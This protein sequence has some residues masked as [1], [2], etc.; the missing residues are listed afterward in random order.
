MKK[1]FKP[2]PILLCL[3][4]ILSIISINKTKYINTLEKNLYNQELY[5][6]ELNEDILV[7]LGLEIDS[8]KSNLKNQEYFIE[9]LWNNQ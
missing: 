1:L 5:I 7:P 3:L 2:I 6:N 9:Q 8:L 4:I